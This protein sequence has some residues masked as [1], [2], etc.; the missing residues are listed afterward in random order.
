MVNTIAVEKRIQL[1]NVLRGLVTVITM[2]DY[3]QGFYKLSL[4][5]ASAATPAFAI[6]A[7]LPLIF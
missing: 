3:V 2:P 5:S 7:G 4:K 6:M 1:I